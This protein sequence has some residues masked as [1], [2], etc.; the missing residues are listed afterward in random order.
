MDKAINYLLIFGLL[1]LCYIIATIIAIII[2]SCKKPKP[3]AHTLVILGC[4]IKGNKPTKSLKRRL[5]CGYKYLSENPNIYCVVS[6]GKG[7]D[8]EISEAECMCYYLVEKGITSNRIITESH[9]VNTKENI[10]NSAKIIKANAMPAN[11]VIATD[12]YHH[13][14]ANIV[15]KKN[16]LIIIG[17]VSCIPSVKMIIINIIRELIAIPVEILKPKENN[18]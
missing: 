14:R 15:A 16:K 5:D 3:T 7:S 10:L 12:F 8:E 6:G 2:V 9:S 11:M 13:L 1:I 4:K 18:Q 17:A